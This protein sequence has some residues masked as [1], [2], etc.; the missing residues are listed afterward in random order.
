[1]GGHSITPLGPHWYGRGWQGWESLLHCSTSIAHWYP[2]VMSPCCWTAGVKSLR[3]HQLSKERRDAAVL[4]GPLHYFRMRSVCGW[5]GRMVTTW[6]RWKSQL[7]AGPSLTASWRGAGAPRYSPPTDVLLAWV[8]VGPQCFLRCLA[9]GRGCPLTVVLI[10]YPL[11][12]PL[13]RER[14]LL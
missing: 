6:Q 3:W 9:R 2:G 12:G 8:G 13:A 14:G 7:H 4:I 5:G 1:M 10:G 11:P